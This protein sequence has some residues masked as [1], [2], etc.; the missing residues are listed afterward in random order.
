MPAGQG[1]T[2]G[3]RRR[4]FLSHAAD[5]DQLLERRYLVSI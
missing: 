5:L 3:S 1:C 4:A 2:G